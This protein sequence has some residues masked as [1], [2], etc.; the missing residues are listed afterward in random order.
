LKNWVAA[1]KKYPVFVGEFGFP[2][3]GNSRYAQHLISY[4]EAHHWGWTEF[5]W[6]D[7][8]FSRFDLLLNGG[9]AGTYEPAPGGMPALETFHGS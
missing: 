1:G 7:N 4:A 5:C 3:P 8:A 9:G 6:G 2:S